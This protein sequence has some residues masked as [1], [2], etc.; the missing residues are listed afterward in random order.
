[1]RPRPPRVPP[2]GFEPGTCRVETGCSIQLSYGGVSPGYAASRTRLRTSSAGFAFGGDPHRLA[3][4]AHPHGG[5]SSARLERQV[6]ALEAGGSSPLSHPTNDGG[7]PLR[8]V[9]AVA[10]IASAVVDC[11]TRAPLAQW[12]SNGLLI[13]RFWVRIPGGV[14]EKH[15]QGPG[16]RSGPCCVLRPPPMARERGVPPVVERCRDF[17]R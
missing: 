7:H 5:C 1:M 15:Q 14:L 6:V 8:R 3:Y 9:A 13:R 10:H 11:T 2:P 4:A 17:R 16:L 12:Q